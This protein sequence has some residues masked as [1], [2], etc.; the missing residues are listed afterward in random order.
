MVVNSLVI[1]MQKQR[2]ISKFTFRPQPK[3]WHL[4][5]WLAGFLKRNGS[6]AVKFLKP[7]NM[8]DL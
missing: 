3:L 1:V 2:V 4:F 6:K 7:E 5:I 8:A